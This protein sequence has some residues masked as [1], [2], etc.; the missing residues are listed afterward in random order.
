MGLSSSGAAGFTMV[1]FYP[2]LYRR[3]LAYS[4]T[5]VNQQWPYDPSLRCGAW[6]YHGAWAGTAG[7]NLNVKLGVVSPATEPPGVPL[8]TTSPAKPIRFWFEVGDQDLFYPNPSNPDGMH[9]WTLSSTRMAQVL[10]EKGYHYQFLF[11]KNAK[12]V[13]RPTVARPCRRRSS[14]CGRAI[15]AREPKGFRRRRFL[16]PGTPSS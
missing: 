15:R 2:E 16:L 7:P 12:H 13:D 1:W 3:V 6:E 10:A 5:M 8:I 14:G 9:D 4:P 11:T